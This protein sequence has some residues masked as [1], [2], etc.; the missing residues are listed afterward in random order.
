MRYAAYSSVLTR[1]SAARRFFFGGSPSPSPSVGASVRLLEDDSPV[2]D[3]ASIFSST[4]AAG[5]SGI[6]ISDGRFIG[7][8]G[9]TGTIGARAGD[10]AGSA[11]DEDDG[12]DS[13]VAIASGTEWWCAIDCSCSACCC[14]W[15]AGRTSSNT[16]I[17]QYPSREESI[18][19]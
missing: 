18:R 4:L 15:Y 19:H 14:V 1:V 6:G 5:V 13:G 17:V 10:I 16:T 8:T 3:E 2:L 9:T 11:T 7:T 12:V